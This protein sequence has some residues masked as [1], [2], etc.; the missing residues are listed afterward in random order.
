MSIV[1]SPTLSPSFKPISIPSNK[2]NLNNKTSNNKNQFN[3]NLLSP[4]TALMTTDN[5]R[6]IKKKRTT[7]HNIVHA[8]SN[9]TNVKHNNNNLTISNEII[10]SSNITNI[11]NSSDNNRPHNTRNTLFKS[12]QSLQSTQNATMID[13]NNSD[14]DSIIDS[15]IP[16]AITMDTDRE[17]GINET[18]NQ[19]NTIDSDILIMVTIQIEKK[20]K[21]Q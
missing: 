11:T 14:N 1:N 18:I 6:S 10:N 7:N 12:I 15:D 4:L 17:D 3:S 8:N 13:E 20:L 2:I 5:D 16:T 21:I 9:N 19:S